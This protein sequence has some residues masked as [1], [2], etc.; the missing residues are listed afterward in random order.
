MVLGQ[1]K[2]ETRKR[3]CLKYDYAT[4]YHKRPYKTKQSRERDARIAKSGP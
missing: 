3:P 2:L 1:T 4:D